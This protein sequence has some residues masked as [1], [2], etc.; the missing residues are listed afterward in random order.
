MKYDLIFSSFLMFYISEIGFTVGV[1]FSF[2]Y[3]N[4]IM[5]FI[6]VFPGSIFIENKLI[7]ISK[8][9]HIT[10]IIVSYQLRIKL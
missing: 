8:L 6:I 7:K 2:N 4:V 3:E 1:N 5:F 10:I 9:A